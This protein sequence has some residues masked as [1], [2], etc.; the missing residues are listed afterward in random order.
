PRETWGVSDGRDDCS[1]LPVRVDL[2][3]EVCAR[4]LA[5]TTTKRSV[6]NRH[7]RHSRRNP[8]IERQFGVTLSGRAPTATS[9]TVAGGLQA[10]GA[11]RQCPGGPRPATRPG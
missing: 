9:T 6:H 3:G 7:N 5:L 1:P 11:G 10:D 4:C 2:A 8:L